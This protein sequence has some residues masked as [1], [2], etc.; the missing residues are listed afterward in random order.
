MKF[1][2][3]NNNESNQKS[4]TQFLSKWVWQHFKI[5]KSL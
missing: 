4:E 1:Q 3:N 2:Q 5:K